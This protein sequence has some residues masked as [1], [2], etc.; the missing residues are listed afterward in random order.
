M[1][2]NLKSI[3]HNALYL[4]RYTKFITARIDRDSR[5]KGQVHHI[6]PA[7]LFPLYSKDKQNLILLQDREHY[8]AHLLLW[9]AL[10]DSKEMQCAFWFMVNTIQNNM[11]Q[12][13]YAQLR[14]NIA[15]NAKIRMSK[16]M[17]GKS[18]YVDHEGN[19]YHLKTD[20]PLIQDLNLLNIS[21]GRKASEETKQKLRKPK[22]LS[23]KTKEWYSSTTA[24][25]T[26]SGYIERVEKTDPRLISGELRHFN[27]GTV[28]VIVDGMRKKISL[29]EFATGEFK[30]I[31]KGMVDVFDPSLGRRTKVSKEDPRFI[32]GEVYIKTQ[33]RVIEKNSK[34]MITRNKSLTGGRWLISPCGT[35]SKNFPSDEIETM[36]SIGWKFG[37]ILR[38]DRIVAKP[39]LGKKWFTDGSTDINCFPGSE[40]EGFSLGK[41]KRAW[42]NDGKETK[43]ILIRDLNEF[44]SSGWSQGRL[45]D[46]SQ[47]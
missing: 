30:H 27:V 26:P 7:S 37:R 35:K 33:E 6:L 23:A 42:I 3:K 4:E 28:N 17:S 47:D 29:E 44:L 8:I 10:P 14:H 46:F 2:E 39:S 15:E 9:K 1:I 24:V 22:V 36:I 13:T 16:T 31:N 11:N 45:K 32:S 25:M 12:K 34:T 38:E 20:D 19:R 41:M 18:T 21:V 43:Q 40:P 5:I